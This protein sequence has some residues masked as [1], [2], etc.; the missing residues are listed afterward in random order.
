MRSQPLDPLL[1][2][3]SPVRVF[4]IVLLLAFATEGAIMLA[5]AVAHGPW[6][7]PL[8]DGLLDASALTLFISPAVWFLVAVPLRRLFHARGELLRR[9]FETQE[10]ER[11]RIAR[12]L[13]D[14]IGQDLTALMVGLRAIE[15]AENLTTAAKRAH[16]LRE[17]AGVAHD[18]VRRL[19]RGLRPVVLEELGLAAALERSCEDFERTHAVKVQLQCD[20]KA[21]RRLDPETETALYRIV[22]EALTNVAR[23]SGASAVDVL[24]QQDESATTLSIRDDGL[25]FDVTDAASPDRASSG[26]GLDS[27]RERALMLGGDCSVRTGRGKGT[28][29]EIRIPVRT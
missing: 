29:L 26:F 15:E 12:D 3:I 23:H 11:A 28:K 22:Q 10:Q 6:R 9:L 2:A 5:L 18:E 7:S 4:A 27:I 13:H 17:F 8:V 14:G 21:A 16:D 25:G 20:S 1:S 24:L 19:A